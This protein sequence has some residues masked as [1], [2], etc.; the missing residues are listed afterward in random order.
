MIFVRCIHRTVVRITAL[1]C[2]HNM[3]KTYLVVTEHF[4]RNPSKPMWLHVESR[5]LSSV[6]GARDMA[7]FVGLVNKNK[8]SKCLGRTFVVQVL[9]T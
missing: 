3:N 7:D 9:D 6:D 1:V 2:A 4:P 5:P 8:K